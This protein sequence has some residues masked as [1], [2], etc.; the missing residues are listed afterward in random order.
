MKDYDLELEKQ[1]TEEG[2]MPEEELIYHAKEML[3]ELKYDVMNFCSCSSIGCIHIV[4]DVLNTIKENK[5]ITYDTTVYEFI[6]NAL[7][8]YELLEHYTNV[9]KSRLTPYGETIL[10]AFE[11]IGD[12]EID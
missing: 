1:L 5:D 7:T 4:R 9:F 10:L 2:F 3:Y 12:D 6:L 11:I 8:S